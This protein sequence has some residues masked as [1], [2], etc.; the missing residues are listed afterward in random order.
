MAS[1]WIGSGEGLAIKGLGIEAPDY[2]VGGLISKLYLLKEA[3]HLRDFSVSIFKVIL[4]T[5]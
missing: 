2:Q 4:C 3:V 5:R 1:L